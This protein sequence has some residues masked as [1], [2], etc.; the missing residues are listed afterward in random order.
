MSTGGTMTKTIWQYSDRLPD[1]TMEFLKGIAIDYSKVK[2]EVYFRY[3]GIKSLD[4]LTPV[5]GILNEM[6]YCGL[7]ERLNLPVVYYELAIMD[8]IADIKGRWGIV[9][10]KI[11]ELVT[12]NE[13]LTTDD[14][15]Y[16]RTVLKDRKSTRLN[17]SH[18]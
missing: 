18:N 15:L 7:R 9:K 8:A 13:N 2:N 14:R 3:A 12:A 6:R 1:E 11:G 4:R 5:Y 16:L 10:N 17:S